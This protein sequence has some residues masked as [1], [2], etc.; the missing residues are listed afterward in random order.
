LTTKY[1]ISASESI[2]LATRKSQNSQVTLIRNFD[3][4]FMTFTVFYDQVDKDS[5]FRF[6]IFPTGLG[7]G[8]S[9]DQVQNALTNQQ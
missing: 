1:A 8:L 6:G 5:G 2:D 9:T 3:R 7:Y 4:F